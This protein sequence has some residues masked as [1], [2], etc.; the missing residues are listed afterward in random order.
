MRN[1]RLVLEYEGTNYAGWQVQT[2]VATIQGTLIEAIKALTGVEPKLTGASRTDAGVHAFGQVANFLTESKIP[3]YNILQGLNAI[4]PEDIAVKSATDAPLDFD[5]RRGS[6]SK[7]YI[8]KVLNRNYPSA[9]MRNF[10]WFVFKPL[11][12]ESMRQGAAHFIGEKDFSSFRAADSD[13][14]HSI[15]E[16]T[17]FRIEDRGDG[18]LE[19]EVKGTAFLRHMVRIMVG[20]TVALGK[21]KLKPS[22]IAKIIEAK[23]RTAAAMT[24]PPQGLCLMKVEYPELAG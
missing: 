18:L 9:L 4:L 17:S 2:G 21:G 11:D 20:T 15:R 23:D 10:S 22:D 6:T 1:I 16:V 19:F 3:A 7:T 12:L 5:S 13:A 24:A 14:P 8:Y